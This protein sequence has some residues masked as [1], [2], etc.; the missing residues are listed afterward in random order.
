MDRDMMASAIA[1]HTTILRCMI[2]RVYQQDATAGLE[3]ARE[4]IAHIGRGY[5]D[6]RPHI[7]TQEI[8]TR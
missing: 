6:A 1:T 4:A 5:G 8:E 7:L 2:E 3:I